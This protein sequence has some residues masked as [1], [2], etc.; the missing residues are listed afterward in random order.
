M[1]LIRMDAI[2]DAARAWD[3]ARRRRAK[4]TDEINST[5]QVAQSAARRLATHACAE[6]DDLAELKINSESVLQRDRGVS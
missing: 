2:E 1:V 3:K 6:R 5:I 4:K